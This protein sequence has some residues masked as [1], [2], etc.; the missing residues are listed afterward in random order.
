M[1]QKQRS[2]FNKS[3]SVL[4]KLF[5]DSF[6]VMLAAELSVIISK[7]VDGLMVSNFMEAEMF[8]AQNLV[9]PFFGLIGITSGLLATGAQVMV[10]KNIA[11]GPSRFLY[12]LV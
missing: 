1:L 5:L 4:H 3:D 2:L 9:G 10:S 7:L 6:W 12:Y 11:S 8:A